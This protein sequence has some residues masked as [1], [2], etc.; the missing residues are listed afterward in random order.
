VLLTLPNGL[1]FSRFTVSAGRSVGNAVQRNRA[2]RVTR[3]A[4]ASYIEQT[5]PGWDVVILTRRTIK[6]ANYQDVK[7]ALGL[8]L[9]EARLIDGPEHKP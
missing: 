4:M 2:K 8:L 6:T 7:T 5:K 1:E 3:A 9:D